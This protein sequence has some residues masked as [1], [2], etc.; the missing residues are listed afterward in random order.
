[1]SRIITAKWFVYYIAM[2][3]LLAGAAQVKK[4]SNS[5]SPELKLQQITDLASKSR[6][7]V[8]T[9]DDATFAYYAV[10]KPRPYSLMVFLTAAHPKF[11]CAV[12][13]NLDYELQFLAKSYAIETKKK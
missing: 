5:A 13:K 12:C 2:I 7:N 1:M 11:K 10:S 4:Q 3:V 6:E 9:L 8:I